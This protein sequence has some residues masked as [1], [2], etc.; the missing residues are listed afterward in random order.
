MA[1]APLIVAGVS[2]L[3]SYMSSQRQRA[4]EKKRALLATPEHLRQV[5]GQLMPFYRELVNAGLGPMFIQ[6]S[7]RAISESGLSGSGVGE[8]LRGLSKAVPTGMAM[9]EA[10]GAAENVVNR[11]IGT[12]PTGQINPLGEALAAGARAYVGMSEARRATGSQAI[13]QS[14]ETP[15]VPVDT[16]Q[17]VQYPSGPLPNEPPLFPTTG[18]SRSTNPLDR[19]GVNI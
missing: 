12:A 5:I 18:P 8:A 19:P 17:P 11:Q 15:M 1:Y 14:N 13:Q 9:Q 16:S 4:A 10:T 2:A 7:A 3:S 6:E